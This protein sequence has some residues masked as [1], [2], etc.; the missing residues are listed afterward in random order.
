MAADGVG[1]GQ[2][3]QRVDHPG[4][5][6]EPRVD[7]FPG[8]RVG[9]HAGQHLQHV[10]LHHVADR[11]GAVVEPAAVGDVERLGHGDLDAVDVGAVEQ[12]LEDGVGEPGDQHVVQRVQPEPVVNSVDRV[13]GEE[14]LHRLVQ[15]LRAGQVGPEGFLHHHPGALGASGLGD[16]FGDAPEQDR[17]HLQVE[18]RPGSV[19][20]LVR[21]RGVGGRV[22]EVAI[23]VAQ[24]SEHR[25]GRR[26]VRVHAVE[27]E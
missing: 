27:L 11:A 14:L 3:A 9:Q 7:A 24:Q 17:W 4:F 2:R 22:V 18:Q 25:S 23:D 13:L 5:G 15:L 19:A 26:A 6:V 8:R 1:G 16:A 12:R 20:D 21:H 10:V